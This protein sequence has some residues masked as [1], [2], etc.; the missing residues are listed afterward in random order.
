[1]QII[2]VAG[3]LQNCGDLQRHLPQQ[4][5]RNENIRKM[6]ILF[7]EFSSY[8]LAECRFFLKPSASQNSKF[9]LIGVSRIGRVREHTNTHTD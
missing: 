1:M 7:G 2:L 8:Q 5:L 4:H 6:A 3:P 9:Q